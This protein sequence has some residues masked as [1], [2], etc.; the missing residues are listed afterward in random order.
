MPTP[1]QVETNHY[2]FENYV[3]T[4]RWGAYWQQ[5]QST[6]EVSPKRVLYIGV[7][8][9]IVPSVLEAM[10]ITV[11]RFDFDEKLG[12]DYVGDVREIRSLVEPESVDVVIC[13]QVLEHIPF[14]GFEKTMRQLYSIARQRL[15]VSLPYS[16]KHLGD[17]SVKIPKLQRITLD[18]RIPSFWKRWKFDGQHHWE[19]GTAGYARRRISETISRVGNISKT[20][21]VKNYKYHL[22]FI[23]DK[24]RKV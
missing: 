6:T 5:I 15:I 8:D 17:I 12:V 22:F 13:C 21:F 20:F 3:S 18:I 1:I 9:N 11:V 19:V 24:P 7:G 4:E 10:G 23:M 2:S 14:D 16:H